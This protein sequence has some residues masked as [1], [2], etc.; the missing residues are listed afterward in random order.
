MIKYYEDPETCRKIKLIVE[1]LNDYLGYIDTS[2][3]KCYRSTGSRSMAYARIHGLSRIWLEA[4]GIRPQY[5]LEVITENYCSLSP[6]EKIKVL[7]HELLHIPKGFTGGLR[8]H[9]KY[10]NGRIVNKLYM[11]LRR[12]L[13]RNN[14]NK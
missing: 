9:G 2:M 14:E 12:R 10:V 11:E 3:I 7:I 6:K 5:I 4:L 8:P 13:E 1:T